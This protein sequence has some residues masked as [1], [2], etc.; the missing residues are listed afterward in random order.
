MGH[1]N[2]ILI[3]LCVTKLIH[4]VSSDVN[5]RFV[6]FAY[7]N[8]KT[9]D[10]LNECQKADDKV[11]HIQAIIRQ[12]NIDGFIQQSSNPHAREI[13]NSKK[14]KSMS[15]LDISFEELDAFIMHYCYNNVHCL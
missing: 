8:G 15:W 4:S 14:V 2:R 10:Q 5:G 1:E 9:I 12:E 3:P 13:S 11:F 6:G 7:A